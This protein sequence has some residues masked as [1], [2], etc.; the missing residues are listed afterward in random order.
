MDYTINN[1]GD[2]YLGS[3][4]VDSNLQEKCGKNHQLDDLL[5]QYGMSIVDLSCGL[6]IREVYTTGE[7]AGQT[8]EE[9]YCHLLNIGCNKY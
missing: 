2:Q 7:F 1:M 8:V 9:V 6:R 3:D 5:N 4:H